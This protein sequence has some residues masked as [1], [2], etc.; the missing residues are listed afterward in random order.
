VQGLLTEF[1]EESNKKESLKN[2]DIFIKGRK[3]LEEDEF[4]TI[5][6]QKVPIIKRSPFTGKLSLKILTEGEHYIKE[7]NGKKKETKFNTENL[8]KETKK[9]IKETYHIG[10]ISDPVD[11]QL[12]VDENTQKIAREI[13][14]KKMEEH[15]KD[16]R[17]IIPEN[18]I[19]SVMDPTKGYICFYL[20]NPSKHE[21]EELKDLYKNYNSAVIGFAVHLPKVSINKSARINKKM[22]E[23]LGLLDN[24]DSYYSE[25]ED[26]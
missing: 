13:Y 7:S 23:E 21:K 19:R 17:K 8:L 25:E 26:D 9:S 12:I 1:I 22:Q 10:N 24:D 4:L 15:Q 3:N 6:Q 20:F 5:N 2:W 16:P 11:L 18:I 14:L